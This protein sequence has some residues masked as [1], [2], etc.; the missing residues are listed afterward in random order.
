MTG[1]RILIAGCGDLGTELGRRLADQG[2]T[3]FGLRRNPPPGTGPIHWLR[4]D[5]TVAKTLAHLPGDLDLVF[6]LATPGAYDDE[7]YRK[8]YVE[9]LGNILTRLSAPPPRRI[10]FV[11]STSVYGQDDG[12]W[13]D[14]ST[15]THPTGFAGRRVLE[16]EE[17]L[18]ASSVPGTVVRF[19]GIYGPGRTRMLRKARA[20]EPVVDNPPWY[21]NRIH[22]EDCV[23]VLEHM[24]GLAAP[25]DLYLAVDNAPCTQAELTDWLCDELGLTRPPR[26]SGG[27]K[28]NKRCRNARLLASGYR[29]HYPTYRE[30]YRALIESEGGSG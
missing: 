23:G 21:T 12:S 10:I 30:G 7:A 6:Y 19:G 28:S 15:P 27:V 13:V 1:Q 5:L 22:R 17:A 9:G 25:D 4:A 20:G 2:H 11:S 26:T 14:E 18:R 16:A 3:V 8:A 24:A 29:F